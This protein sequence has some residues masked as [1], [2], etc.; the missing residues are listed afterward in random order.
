MS[1]NAVT[2]YVVISLA[3]RITSKRQ[4]IFENIRTN[5]QL[6]WVRL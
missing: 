1:N 5:S 4:S 6:T 2:L 3:E